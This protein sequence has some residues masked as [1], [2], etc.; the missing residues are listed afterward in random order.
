MQSTLTQTAP[1][2]ELLLYPLAAPSLFSSFQ[3]SE[4]LGSSCRGKLSD[5]SCHRLTAGKALPQQYPQS[6][7]KGNTHLRLS[8]R[9]FAISSGVSSLIRLVPGAW[10]FN[11]I[12]TN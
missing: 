7:K 12:K 11:I 2:P 10:L 1:F 6:G 8:S 5:L 4:M 3:C 9:H